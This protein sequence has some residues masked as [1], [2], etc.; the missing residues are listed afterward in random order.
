MSSPIRLSS[1]TSYLPSW[2][3]AA[4]AHDS[5]PVASPA[6]RGFV[7][8]Q[9][10]LDRLK[11]RLEQETNEGSRSAVGRKGEDEAMFS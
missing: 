11:M 9:S 6:K 1:F 10:Q 4:A 3:T 7:S 5:T 2:G 8:K